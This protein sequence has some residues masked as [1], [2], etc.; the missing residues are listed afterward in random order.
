MC[1]RAALSETD[2]SGAALLAAGHFVAAGV[3][4]A[5]VSLHTAFCYQHTAHSSMAGIESQDRTH[6]CFHIVSGKCA[7]RRPG[8]STREKKPRL[9][10]DAWRHFITKRV[11]L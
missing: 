11:R 4:C 7:Y 2:E 6:D 3:H 5:E 9:K 1:T 8:G 10:N